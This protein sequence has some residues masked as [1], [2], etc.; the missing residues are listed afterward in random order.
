MYYTFLLYLKVFLISVIVVASMAFTGIYIAKNERKDNG[1]PLN[2]ENKNTTLKEQGVISLT[3][4]PILKEDTNADTSKW[5]VFTSEQYNFTFRYPQEYILFSDYGVCGKGLIVI[6]YRNDK[7]QYNGESLGEIDL[8]RK[9]TPSGLFEY[10]VNT[11]INEHL[12]Q[13]DKD[14]FQ[15]ILN[16]VTYQKIYDTV[17]QIGNGP[18]G[19]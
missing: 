19:E 8:G 4:T 1:V 13:E 6:F 12:S 5:K 14:V 2:I 18:C 16:T 10:E 15:Q 3:P 11:K 9:K 7:A 17:E